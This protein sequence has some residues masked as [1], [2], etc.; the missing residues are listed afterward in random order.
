M[1]DPEVRAEGLNARSAE[2]IFLAKYSV[3]PT[4]PLHAAREELWRS[5][6]AIAA[7]QEP[8]G[9]PAM[10]ERHRK[11]ASSQTLHRIPDLPPEFRASGI[12]HAYYFSLVPAE[13]KRARRHGGGIFLR[14][15]PHTTVFC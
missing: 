9:W 5:L 12:Y 13:R 2:R 14:W 4:H 8:L 15:S 3:F 7:E 11:S 1:I 10:P 6:A